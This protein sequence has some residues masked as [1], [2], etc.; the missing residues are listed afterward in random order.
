[1]DNFK[2]PHPSPLPILVE[3]VKF[4]AANPIPFSPRG[5][6]APLGADEGEKWEAVW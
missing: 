1:M 6:G 3:G 5:E 4:A 2:N